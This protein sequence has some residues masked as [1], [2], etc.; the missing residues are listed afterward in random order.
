[1]KDIPIIFSAP[2]VRALLDG[3]KTMTRRLAWKAPREIEGANLR[4]GHM[5]TGGKFY[6]AAPWQR[7]KPGDRLWVREGWKPHSLYAGMKPREMPKANIFYLADDKYSPSNITGRPSIF[8]P[9]WASRLTL[10]VSAVKIERLQK[11]TNA[12]AIA[13]GCGVNFDHDHPERTRESFPAERFRDLWMKLHGPDSWDANPDI[14]AIN[15][16]VHKINI[17]ALPKVDAA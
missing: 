17:D 14:V 5:I 12:D 8:M 16:A 3:R 13:E 15:F 9:R 1:V 10:V 7:V 2:M 11:I 4:L 6:A